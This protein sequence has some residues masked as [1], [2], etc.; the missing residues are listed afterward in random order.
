MKESRW[1]K[2]SY[3]YMLCL[4]ADLMAKFGSG[5]FAQGMPYYLYQRDYPVECECIRQELDEGRTVSADEFR[6]M[7]EARREEDRP[8][9]G[10]QRNGRRG[11]KHTSAG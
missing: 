6:A 9:D 11:R 7:K 5:S 10:H 3:I 4:I 8:D 1:K 2:R